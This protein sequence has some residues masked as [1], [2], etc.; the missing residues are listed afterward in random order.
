V[1]KETIMKNSIIAF[2]MLF[3]FAACAPDN[4]NKDDDIQ[5]AVELY[6]K[7][8]LSAQFGKFDSAMIYYDKAIALDKSFYDPHIG[9]RSI[10]LR[11]QEYE[12]ALNESESIIAKSDLDSISVFDWI[13]TGVLHEW[14]GDT[15]SA[16]RYYWSSL[17]FYEKQL[18]YSNPDE[19]SD[20]KSKNWAFAH[21][22]L[23]NKE[24]AIEELQ[25]LKKE[26]PSDSVAINQLI[27]FDKNDYIKK[28]VEGGTSLQSNE[29]RIKIF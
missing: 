27:H 15:T 18:E 6:K 23:G 2:I 24:M 9:K 19:N 26:N 21:M 1:K 20:F 11:Q 28:M 22:L 4:S 8:R 14:H 7:G 13:F 3:V 25:K 12:K 10:Y 16:F 17:G 5:K 29:K